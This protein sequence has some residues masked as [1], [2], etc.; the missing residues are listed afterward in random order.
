MLGLRKLELRLKEVPYLAGETMTIADL[1]IASCLRSLFTLVFGEVER[2]NS[3]S[4]SAWV[5]NLYS[6]VGMIKGNREELKRDD[7]FY[8]I[9]SLC[10]WKQLVRRSC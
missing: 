9:I 7:L 6:S 5:T 10:I 8:L 4:M 3:P 1:V 2:K